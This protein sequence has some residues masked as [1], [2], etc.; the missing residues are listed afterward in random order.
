MSEQPSLYSQKRMYDNKAA[1]RRMGVTQ[2]RDI[3]STHNFP[4]NPLKCSQWLQELMGFCLG[5]LFSALLYLSRALRNKS[6]EISVVQKVLPRNSL[7]YLVIL[8]SIVSRCLNGA[9]VLI[10]CNGAGKKKILL[11]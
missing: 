11:V 5:I 1:K 4:F 8:F 7:K 3:V 10:P 6:H 9:R 2:S